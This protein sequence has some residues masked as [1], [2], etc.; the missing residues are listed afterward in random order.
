MPMRPVR[1]RSSVQ[2]R[3]NGCRGQ[4][5]REKAKRFILNADP[6]G[7]G[8]RISTRRF[9]HETD[10]R[11]FTYNL[12]QKYRRININGIYKERISVRAD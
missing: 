12:S 7:K 5:L 9:A 6:I 8:V 3:R 1:C 4:I 10:R 11:H 2:F